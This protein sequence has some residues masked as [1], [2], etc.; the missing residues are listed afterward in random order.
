MTTTKPNTKYTITAAHR[1]TGKSRTTIQKHVKK[2]KLAYEQGDDGVKLIDASEL[3][4]VYGDA[5][6]FG[7]AEEGAAATQGEPPVPD[8]VR[9][10]LHTLRDRLDNVGEERRREREQLQ[11]QIDHLQDALKRAQEGG[12]R[13][14][15]LLE[16]RSGGGDWQAAIAGLEAKL[17][18]EERPDRRRGEAA[19]SGRAARPPLVAF[20]LGIAPRLESPP[21]F[22]NYA[23]FRPTGNLTLLRCQHPIGWAAPRGRFDRTASEVVATACSSAM[24]VSSAAGPTDATSVPNE[25]ASVMRFQRRASATQRPPFA[26]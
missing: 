22:T 6:D 11:A 5:C 7:R 26:S 19:R 1:I 2:G 14:L 23:S 21:A 8:A 10:E 15:L 3:I 9:T 18:A 13:A 17:T 20:G 24:L 25:L 16:D 12:N 4:R